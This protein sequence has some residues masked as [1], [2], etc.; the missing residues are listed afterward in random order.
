MNYHLHFVEQPDES[1]M[2]LP[3]NIHRN[4]Q[5][6]A[7]GSYLLPLYLEN[8]SK[9]PSARSR[10]KSTQLDK[11]KNP[12]CASQQNGK[13]PYV[14]SQ[15]DFRTPAEVFRL[16]LYDWYRNTNC[17][18]FGSHVFDISQRI[19]FSAVRSILPWKP[20]CAIFDYMVNVAIS[21]RCCERSRVFQPPY[22]SSGK[23]L[24]QTTGGS[25]YR[26]TYQEYTVLTWFYSPR[27]PSILH[28]AFISE[29]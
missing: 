9:S 4:E 23:G 11:D 24:L 5:L 21:K 3:R 20:L 14:L 7:G 18:T 25:K 27:N 29:E 12:P 15:S 13:D 26:Q 28:F 6:P 16:L 2:V 17:H 1:L 8:S 22:V 19:L 10:R